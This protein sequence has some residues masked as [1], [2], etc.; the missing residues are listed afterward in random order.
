MTEAASPEAALV[1][2]IGET[3]A[4]LLIER[5]GGTR[6]TVPVSGGAL[7]AE[8]GAEAAAR[9]FGHFGHDRVHVP[10]AKAWRAGIYRQRGMSYSAIARKLG[11][12]E[13]SVWKHLHPQPGREQYSLS[14]SLP[15]KG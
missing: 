14:L 7:A 15:E 6:I 3:A 12:N 11:C 2:L 9:L 13:A 8:I 5:H 4:L 10:L 1:A